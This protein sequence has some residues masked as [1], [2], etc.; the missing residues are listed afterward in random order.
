[1]TF[2]F[3]KLERELLIVHWHTLE[4][5]LKQNNFTI[6]QQDLIKKLYFEGF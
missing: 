5:K 3:S 4:K 6:V 1:M 2:P